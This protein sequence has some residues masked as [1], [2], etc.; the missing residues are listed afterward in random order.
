MNVAGLLVE[1]DV[2][3]GVQRIDGRGVRIKIGVVLVVDRFVAG[4][5]GWNIVA[6]ADILL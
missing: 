4:R 1:F 6:Q 5:I 3:A 2:E